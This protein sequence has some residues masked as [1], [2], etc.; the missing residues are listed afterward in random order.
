[1]AELSV[2]VDH[3]AY[4]R[5]YFQLNVPD[6]SHIAVLAEMAGA[7]SIRC[8]LKNER[9]HIRERDVYL[10]KEIVKSRLNLCIAPISEF[11]DM[12]IE[13]Q[14]WIVTLMPEDSDSAILKRG[15]DF[16]FAVEKCLR[17]SETFQDNNIN[18]AYFIEPEESDVKEAARGRAY[19]VELCA[20][21][22]IN[23][24]ND[25][26]RQ[27]EIDRLEN[28]SELA[29]K[30]GMKTS[31]GSGLSYKNISALVEL[32]TFDSF[33]VGSAIIA[34]AIMVGFEQAIDEMIDLV[35]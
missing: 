20:D 16:E 34:R 14:P 23:A 13:V 30:L 24:K 8:Y 21:D 29:I 28:M 17:A 4:L 9:S 12:A 19:A 26:E 3:I 25:E 32:E 22:Y 2:K 33:S 7:D 10:L 15:I 31:C 5:N 18:V 1:M 35:E 27:I 11:V 6:P